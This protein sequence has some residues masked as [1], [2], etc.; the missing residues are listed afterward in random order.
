[1]A[2]GAIRDVRV[3]AHGRSDAQ[4]SRSVSEAVAAAAEAAQWA[5]QKLHA[6]TFGA[7]RPL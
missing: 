6:E 3:T 7:Y 4:V 1:M 2:D 5:R